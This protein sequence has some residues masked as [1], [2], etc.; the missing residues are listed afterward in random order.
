[1]GW[2]PVKVLCHSG[3]RLGERPMAV[4]WN[5]AEIVIKRIISSSR[6]SGTEAGS[7]IYDLFEVVLADG[8]RCRLGY[9]SARDTWDI[10]D[11]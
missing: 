11:L 1:M 9:D 7:V 2:R 6:Q 8:R 10:K 3:Y 4:V 5:D